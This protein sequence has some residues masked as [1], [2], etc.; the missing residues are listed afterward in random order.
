MGIG[1]RAI[2]LFARSYVGLDI[3]IHIFVIE[4]I[5]QGEATT[6]RKLIKIREDKCRIFYSLTMIRVI[7]SQLRLMDREIGSIWIRSKY[8][9]IT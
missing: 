2:L 6:I 7:I 1:Y 5:A 3:G 8:V 9:Q 4:R